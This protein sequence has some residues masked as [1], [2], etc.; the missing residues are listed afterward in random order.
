MALVCKIFKKKQE[1]NIYFSLRA[2]LKGYL[3]TAV[4]D[5][6]KNTFSIS[7]QNC[8]TTGKVMM[9]AQNLAME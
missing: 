7:T 5:H 6:I 2:K 8:G 4:Y 3:V 1:K 9:T